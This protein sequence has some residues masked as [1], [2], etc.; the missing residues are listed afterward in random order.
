ML[1]PG[2]PFQPSLMFVSKAGAYPSGTSFQVVSSGVGSLVAL[3]INIELS[4]E[5]L[6][7]DQHFG[8]LQIFVIY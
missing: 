5:K 3:P 2:K 4:K 1:A 8:F 6:A 7:M